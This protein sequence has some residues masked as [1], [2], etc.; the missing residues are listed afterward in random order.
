VNLEMAILRAI[1]A[2]MGVALILVGADPGDFGRVQQ[3][4]G[5]GYL[6]KPLPRLL[7]WDGD[8]YSLI[9]DGPEFVLRKMDLVAK[10][11]RDLRVRYPPAEK[12]LWL[13]ALAGEQRPLLVFT[14]YSV[15]TSDRE[16]S[17]IERQ[18]LAEWDPSGGLGTLIAEYDEV[19]PFASSDAGLPVYL[20]PANPPGGDRNYCTNRLMV[21][22]L[23][24][25][26]RFEYRAVR[27]QA[28]ECFLAAI[29]AGVDRSGAFWLIYLSEKSLLL[30]YPFLERGVVHRARLPSSFWDPYSTLVKDIWSP[31]AFGSP[32][33]PASE[34]SAVLGMARWSPAGVPE[35]QVLWIRWAGRARVQPV[36]RFAL[37]V[38]G[39]LDLLSS[40]DFLILTGTK[41]LPMS[42]VLC[43]RSGRFNRKR[44][45]TTAI[46][47]WD[48][49]G[50]MKARHTLDGTFFC[51]WSYSAGEKSTTLLASDPGTATAE[52]FDWEFLQEK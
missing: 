44:T 22:R 39:L 21:G 11:R 49:Q 50:V 14:R 34:P 13:V 8:L 7:E 46:I 31:T 30:I 17:A 40:S 48:S 12:P 37:R 51:T 20:F 19:V 1:A 23:L 5:S 9:Q 2:V 15:F 43:H 52:R 28:Q 47:A 38:D 24:S 6:P 32:V 42:G 33:R 3:R 4:R 18:D 10:V 35:V 41:R 45:A 29:G 36:G 16:L 27:L 25:R 26:A